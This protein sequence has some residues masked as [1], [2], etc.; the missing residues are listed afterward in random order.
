MSA[1]RGR[2]PARQ[3]ASQLACRAAAE[4]KQQRFGAGQAGRHLVGELRQQRDIQGTDRMSPGR[5][6]TVTHRY[7]SAHP[8]SGCCS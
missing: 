2:S 1:S 6:T 5:T 7:Q 8:C 4:L 3:P